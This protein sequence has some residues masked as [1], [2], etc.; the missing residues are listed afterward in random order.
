VHEGEIE[1][2]PVQR[3]VRA[4]KVVKGD[5]QAQREVH[6]AEEIARQDPRRAATSTAAAL[7]AA[8]ASGRSSTKQRRRQLIADAAER[9]RTGSSLAKQRRRQLI[10]EAAERRRSGGSAGAGGKGLEFVPSKHAET[11]LKKLSKSKG[12]W[13]KLTGKEA[14][15]VGVFLHRVMEGLVGHLASAGWHIVGRQAITPTAV[16]EWR[17]SGRRVALVEARLPKDG[18]LPRLDLAEINFRDGRVSV[19]DY[20]PTSDAAHLAKTSEYA[21]ELARLTGMPASAADVNYVSSG[22]LASDL[23]MP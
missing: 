22:Q 16:A 8:N 11:A 9:Q 1:V 21:A 2:C 7:D 12:D 14:R 19:I 15:A 10:A 23:P 17:A 20:V 13:S 3:C 6:Q 5:D 4:G 18:R